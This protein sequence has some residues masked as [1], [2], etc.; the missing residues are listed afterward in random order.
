MQKSAALSIS[1]DKPEIVAAT[2]DALIKIAKADHL[3]DNKFQTT[4]PETNPVN[5][6]SADD[7]KQ[8]G[9]RLQDV[10]TGIPLFEADVPQGIFAS[11]NIAGA[12]KYAV[13]MM[14]YKNSPL[15]SSNGDLLVSNVVSMKIICD[16]E[17]CN[18]WDT[19]DE[20]T[21]KIPKTVDTTNIVV[22]DTDGSITKPTYVCKYWDRVYAVWKTDGCRFVESLE[23]H[24]VCAC[25]HTTEYAV[26]LD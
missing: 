9:R 15:P 2:S 18:A 4:L 23:D 1:E 16:G 17:E 24:F 3:Q 12:D 14:Q 19:S 26:S 8:S 22:D 21:L 11:G 13:S 6:N 25:T 10:S 7:D 20:I 5:P